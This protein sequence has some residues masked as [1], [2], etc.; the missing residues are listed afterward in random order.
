MLLKTLKIISIAVISLIVLLFVAIKVFWFVYSQ[1]K[2]SEKESQKFLQFKD[3]A[4][5]VNE[6]I[7]ENFGH[8]ADSDDNIV[9]VS[10]ENGRIVGLYDEG[11]IE[12]PER[13]LDDFNSIKSG[14]NQSDTDFFIEIKTDRISYGGLSYR[15]YVYSRNGKAPSY[16]YYKGDGQHPEVYDLGDNWYLLTI[17]FI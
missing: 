12:I 5:S 4:E 9:Y 2:Y 7:I 17:N 8:N 13:L 10:Q 15:M 3:S 11:H 1:P 14:M 6:Y 16:Y